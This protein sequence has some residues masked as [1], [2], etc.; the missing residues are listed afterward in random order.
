MYGRDLPNHEQLAQYAPPTIS[1]IYSGEGRMMDEFARERRLF[2]PSEE[3]PDLVKQA[4]ISA[5]RTR[6]STR[7][8]GYDPRGMLAA[9]T[10]CVARGGRLRGAST[11]TQQV[12]KNFLLSSDRSAERKIKEL[13]LAARAGRQ[14]LEQGQDPGALSERDFPRPEQFWSGRRR[15]DLFQQDALSQLN[16]ARGGLSGKC[17]PNRHQTGIP[18]A[19]W[20]QLWPS[21]AGISC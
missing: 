6:I 21:S 10:G 20:K 8:K 18:S 17:C 15:A 13:I 12:M 2:A 14:T 19:I 3:I 5:P 7:H 11:I 1:R 4:F 9:G 16:A